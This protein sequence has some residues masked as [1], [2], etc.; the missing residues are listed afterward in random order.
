MLG[1]E[2]NCYSGEFKEKER[3]A[4]PTFHTFNTMIQKEDY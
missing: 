3:N 1:Q 4:D 2:N